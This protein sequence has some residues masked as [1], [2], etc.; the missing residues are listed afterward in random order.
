[1]SA[2]SEVIRRWPALSI[3]L[4]CLLYRAPTLA[5]AMTGRQQSGERLK[6]LDVSLQLDDS[7]RRPV[8][9]CRVSGVR[10]AR[11]MMPFCLMARRCG[12]LQTLSGVGELDRKPTDGYILCIV[13]VMGS[14]WAS[15]LRPVI[16]NFDPVIVVVDDGRV[17]LVACSCVW[18]PCLPPAATVTLNGARP[19]LRDARPPFRGRLGQW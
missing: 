6:A 16:R 15:S 10:S 8:V 5:N 13:T 4:S 7:L 19:T 9:S 17:V 14:V 11:E 3:R 1:V 2:H 18:C 12:T